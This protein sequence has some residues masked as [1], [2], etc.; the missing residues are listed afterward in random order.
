[1]PCVS[2]SCVCRIWTTVI[3]GHGEAPP[4]YYLSSIPLRVSV[5]SVWILHSSWHTG[6]LALSR[7]TGRYNAAAMVCAAGHQ[8]PRLNEHRDVAWLWQLRYPELDQQG[9]SRLRRRPCQH[10][11]WLYKNCYILALIGAPEE[12]CAPDFPCVT[13]NVLGWRGGCCQMAIFFIVCVSV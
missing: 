9:C 12:S 6:S 10:R 2:S 7:N 1:V 13:P 3:N 5:Q 11:E 8:L 4:P